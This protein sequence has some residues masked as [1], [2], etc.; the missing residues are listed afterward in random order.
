[1]EHPD[2]IFTLSCDRCCEQCVTC[3]TPKPQASVQVLCAKI[4]RCL[5]VSAP[6]HHPWPE[7]SSVWRPGLGTIG[8]AVG[9]PTSRRTHWRTECIQTLRCVYIAIYVGRVADMPGPEAQRTLLTSNEPEEIGARLDPVEAGV[10][11]LNFETLP[12]SCV[13]TL[14]LVNLAHIFAI[15][16]VILG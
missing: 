6:H 11:L 3:Y 5:F 10:K 9:A 16:A 12:F 14:F 8:T 2:V 13:H 4:P 7:K 15:L 1:M